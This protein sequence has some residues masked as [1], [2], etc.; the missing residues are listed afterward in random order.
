MELICPACG[1]ADVRSVPILWK[2]ISA[3]AHPSSDVL[4]AGLSEARVGRSA[5]RALSQEDQESLLADELA[6]PKKLAD[7]PAGGSC[8]QMLTGILLILAGLAATV[9]GVLRLVTIH[10]T[11]GQIVVTALGSLV[12]AA[13]GYSVFRVGAPKPTFRQY[14]DR[15]AAWN[16]MFLCVKCGNRFAQDV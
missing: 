6:P 15:V 9:A 12:V 13:V 1:S 16:C 2:E 14:A 10:L 4:A 5:A 8:R 11:M 3:G 7:L